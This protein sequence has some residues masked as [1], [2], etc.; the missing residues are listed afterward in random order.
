VAAFSFLFF[1]TVGASLFY[2]NRFGPSEEDLE[3]EILQ[4]YQEM[5][6]EDGIAEKNK[7]VGIMFGQV[8]DPKGSPKEVQARL[9]AVMRGGRETR[10]RTQQHELGRVSEENN[11]DK[12]KD[13]ESSKRKDEEEESPKRKRRRKKKKKKQQEEEEQ[14]ENKD[15]Q[16]QKETNAA[17]AAAAKPPRESSSATNMAVVAGIA[18]AAAVAGF[19]AGGRRSS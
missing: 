18:T 15:A 9:D 5:I 8:F 19:F 14:K 16:P 3:S 4:R 13:E 1:P 11:D 17:A 10:A 7:Q 6:Q 12:S 2:A